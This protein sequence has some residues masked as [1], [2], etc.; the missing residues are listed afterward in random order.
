M[1]GRIAFAGQ[2]AAPVGR[3]R[4]RLV[5]FAVRPL[6]IRVA[7]EDVIGA[8]LDQR[9]IQLLTSGH[10][11]ADCQGVDRVAHLRLGVGLIDVGESGT[12]DHRVGP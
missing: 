10:Q 3:Q 1:L 12:V 8:D 6:A 7:S 2:L 5:V 4:L 9:A 11:I